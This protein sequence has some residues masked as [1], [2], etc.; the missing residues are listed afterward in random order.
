MVWPRRIVNIML[1]LEK[2]RVGIILDHFQT[3]C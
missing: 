3:L 1:F 2:A